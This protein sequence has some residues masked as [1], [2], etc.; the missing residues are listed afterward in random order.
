M[1]L[2]TMVMVMFAVMAVL[3]TVVGLGTTLGSDWTT[4]SESVAPVIALIA[5]VAIVLGIA[6]GRD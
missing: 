1:N 3:L 6:L 4:V 5:I 2:K